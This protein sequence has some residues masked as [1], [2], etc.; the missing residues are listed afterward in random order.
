MKKKIAAAL[1]IF[2]CL[3]G[4]SAQTPVS[5]ESDG[6]AR[7]T[8]SNPSETPTSE[9]NTTLGTYTTYTEPDGW[10][11][12]EDYSTS[13]KIFYVQE[14]REKDKTPDNI[15]VSTGINRYAAEEHTDF[16]NAIMQQLLMQIKGTDAQLTGDGSQTEQGYILYTFTIEE[17]DA[18]TRQYYIVKD[19]E[20]CLVHVTNFTKSES[21]YEA[22]QTIVNSFT[23]VDA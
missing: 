16:K 6:A 19:Y 14:G 15:A 4:C 1:G 10:V 22:A 18:V 8:V 9:E 12:A 5:Q 17:P 13:D 11:K 21:V 3:T 7:S 23:W 20:F 2:F